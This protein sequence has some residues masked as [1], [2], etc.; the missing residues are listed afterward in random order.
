[1]NNNNNNMK[2][3]NKN[4]KMTHVMEKKNK[5]TAHNKNK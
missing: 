1:M 2:K 5:K 4:M 3:N